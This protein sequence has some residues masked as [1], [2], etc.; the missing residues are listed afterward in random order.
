MNWKKGTNS[1]LL[2][3][4]FYEARE[5]LKNLKIL[6]YIIGYSYVAVKT[7]AG[8]GLAYNF[9]NASL[10]D[11][12]V[13]VSG[14]TGLK[15]DVVKE[16]IYK[17]ELLLNSITIAMLNSLL[18]NGEP[19]R[20]SLYERFDFKDKVVGMVGDFKPLKEN[21]KGIARRLDIFELKDIPGTIKPNFA[22]LYLKDADFLI[23]TGAA[24]ANLTVED[25]LNFIPE[26]CKIIF[27][28]PSA[29]L[30]NLLSEIGYVAGAAVRDEE[31]CL[32]IVRKGGGMHSL[33][34]HMNKLWLSRKG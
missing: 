18:K 9:P 10:T 7:E 5:D 14:I 29:P 33:K 27:A 21:I 19:D 30:S 24:F 11:C 20:S 15:W 23:V 6:D 4:I 12:C 32:E 17:G 1:L 26:S 28:G 31:K 8:V 22:K 34:N 2:E 16:F 13:S 25:Y 3:E